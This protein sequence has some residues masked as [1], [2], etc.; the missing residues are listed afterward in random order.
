MAT[1]HREFEIDAPSDKAW[2][3]LR[4]VG[5]INK[6][7]TFLGDVTVEGDRRTCALGDQGQLDELIISV[8][9]ERRRL[10]YAIVDSPFNFSHHSASMQIAANGGAGSRFIW[11][12][13]VKP[14]EAASALEPAIDAAV[15]SFKQTL[16]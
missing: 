14:D 13:D 16:K 5:D 10:A 15:E 1:I 9:D 6:L 7:L 11:I 8:D 4:N 2:D 3:A 12:T